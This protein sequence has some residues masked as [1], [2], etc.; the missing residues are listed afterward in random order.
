M[1]SNGI[2]FVPIFVKIDQNVPKMECGDIQT[3]AKKFGSSWMIPTS[4]NIGTVTFQAG[5]KH[6]LVTY[7]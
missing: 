3:H 7:E 6:I 4:V 1:V 5:R 2:T